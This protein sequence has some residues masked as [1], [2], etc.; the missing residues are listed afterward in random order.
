M[1]QGF[2]FYYMRDIFPLNY[3]F[4]NRVLCP[5]VNSQ[6]CREDGGR[7]LVAASIRSTLFTQYW[8]DLFYTSETTEIKAIL[9]DDSEGFLLGFFVVLLIFWFC[10]SYPICGQFGGH[11]GAHGAVRECLRAFFS[12]KRSCAHQIRISCGFSEQPN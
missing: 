3:R 6:V 10:F 9:L 11:L 7:L 12:R 1:K 5:T 4:R 8:A 2:L